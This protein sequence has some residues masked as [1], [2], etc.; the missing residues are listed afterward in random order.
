MCLIVFAWQ[1]A[2]NAPLVLAANR[3]EFYERP[4]APAQWWEDHPE[5][6]AGRD[7][8]SGGTWL[9]VTKDG[10]FAA[11]TNVRAPSENRDDRRSRGLLVSDYLTKHIDPE[12]YIANISRQA[13][14]YNGF[15]LIVGTPDK[16][17]WYN[18]RDHEDSRNGQAL[19]PGLYGLSNDKLDTPWPKVVRTKAQFASLLCQ[20]APRD[21]YFEMLMDTSRPSDCRLPKTGVD[22]TW[23]RILSAV[24]IESPVYGTRSSSVLQVFPN[25][26][27]VLLE[28]IVSRAA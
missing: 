5:V 15:N 17:I 13:E 7:L 16:L 6:F 10:R 21:A 28:H 23:E 19:A 3:D 20:C 4:T 12:D 27:P 1:V 9:G 18:N 2:P 22:L 8:R 14:N 25:Q 26:A 24:F 11:L